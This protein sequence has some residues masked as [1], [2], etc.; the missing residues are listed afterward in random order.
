MNT[1][2]VMPTK[3]RPYFS[4]DYLFGFEE[5]RRAFPGIPELQ[6]ESFDVP[7]TEARLEIVYEGG[8]VFFIINGVRDT[9]AYP[10]GAGPTPYPTGLSWAGKISG[11]LG[12][13]CGCVHLLITEVLPDGGKGW[14]RQD[15]LLFARRG[16]KRA[17][18]RR[19][20][21]VERAQE[22]VRP[23]PVED[24]ED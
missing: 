17:R 18:R 14:A 3:A 1:P 21:L 24:D 7:F 8:L 5:I 4:T 16:E 22:Y 10:M 15:D 9:G 13:G 19:Q 20:Y 11:H 23:S 12:D 6:G 2:P